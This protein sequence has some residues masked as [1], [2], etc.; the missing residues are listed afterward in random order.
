MNGLSRFSILLNWSGIPRK[1]SLESKATRTGWRTAAGQVIKDL[2]SLN[3][4]TECDFLKVGEKLLEFRSTARQIASDMAAVSELFAGEHGRNA[5]HAL[6]RVLEHSSE[7]DAQMEQSSRAMEEVRDLS[8]RIRLAFAGLRNRVSV[9]KT[10]CTLT[11]IETSRLESTGVDFGDLAAEVRPLSESIQSSGEAILEAV[12]RLEQGVQSA[13]LSGSSLKVKQLKELP[14]LIAGVINDLKAIEERRQRAVEL[15]TRQAEQ[16]AEVCDAIDGVVRS[17]QFH[18]I[19]RQQIEHVMQALRELHKRSENG[20]KTPESLP[21]DARVILALQSSQ[22]SGSAGVFA[23]SI[24]NM[25]RDLESIAVRAQDMAQASRELAGISTDDQDSFFL[26]MEADFT[27]I[28]KML[29]D[30][31]TA[32]ADMQSTAQKLE[33]IIAG[34]QGS[35][36]EIRGIEIRIQ[37]IATNATIQATHIGAAGDALNVIAGVMRGLALDSNT[38]TE[39]VAETLHQMTT[40]S[41]CVSGGSGQ[42][43]S[44]ANSGTEDVIEKMKNTVVEL[45]SSNETSIGRV[46]QIAALSAGLAQDIGAVR[47]GFSAGALVAEVVGRALGE[48]ERMGAQAGAAPLALLDPAQTDQLGRLAKQYTMQKERD[49]HESVMRGSAIAAAPPIAVSKVALEDGGLGDNVELF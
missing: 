14:T 36:A 18:D 4:S 47:S 39:G 31:T 9:F 12:S 35:V 40:A 6:N 7:M 10:L 45:H 13:I 29:D 3:R 26:R 22:L 15:S 11:Q 21:S 30:C 8:C 25:E 37:R 27:A 28:V 34:M 24:E 48:L 17:V 5:S 42:A 1:R 16:Y 2:E 20:R 38:N 33:E 49:V 19:T 44:G 41:S 32:Q 43:A 46:N 23:T